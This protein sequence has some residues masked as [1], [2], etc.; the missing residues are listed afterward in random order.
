MHIMRSNPFGKL[1]KIKEEYSCAFYFYHFTDIQNIPSILNHKCLYSRKQCV[2]LGISISDSASGEIIAST[3]DYK[4]DYV[5]LYFR[6]LT[7]MQYRI[8][9]FVPVG[10]RYKDAHC[11]IPVFLLFDSMPLLIRED[12]RFSE[13]N[14]AASGARP[15]EKRHFEHLP[16]NEIYSTGALSPTLSS[17]KYHRQAEVLFKKSLPLTSLKFIVCRSRAEHRMLQLILARNGLEKWS[18]KVVL[19]PTMK[20]FYSQRLYV[21]ETYLAEGYIFVS[22]NCQWRFQKVEIKVTNISSSEVWTYNIDQSRESNIEFED[23]FFKFGKYYI[24]IYIDDILAHELMTH[25]Y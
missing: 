17:E 24:E 20:L 14:F 25:I 18:S 7:P 11:P 15:K 23:R 10:S 1:N 8:E 12:F 21:K 4:K 5:R 3:D 13:V 16:F 6:P 22:F 9:G 2:D 19:L